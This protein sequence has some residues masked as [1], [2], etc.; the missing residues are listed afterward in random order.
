MR[1]KGD[2]SEKL[3]IA[4]EWP[5]SVFA[6]TMG[7]GAVFTMQIFSFNAW[8]PDGFEHRGTWIKLS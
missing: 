1:L 4:A 6:S 5:S 7:F 3:I 8:M 2:S